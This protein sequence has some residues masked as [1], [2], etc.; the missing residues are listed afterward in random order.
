MKT[1]AKGAGLHW[2]WPAGLWDSIEWKSLPKSEYAG[3]LQ[4]P[5]ATHQGILRL[6]PDFEIEV[7]Q[8]SD[9]QR[10]IPEE[11]LRR[12]VEWLQAG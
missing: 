11:E 5:W 3:C 7:L 8:L 2:S 9:G 4:L 10:I 6:A 1:P 12:F